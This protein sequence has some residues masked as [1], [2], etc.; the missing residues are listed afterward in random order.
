MRRTRDR[1][2]TLIEALIVSTI[3]GILAVLAVVGYRRWIQSSYLAEAQDMVSNIRSAE[4]SFKAENGGYLPVSLGLGVGSDYPAATPGAF[5]TGWGAACDLKICA[6]ANSWKQLGVQTDAPVIFGYSVM[7][8]N[9][10]KNA[11]PHILVQGVD[12][13]LDK[14]TGAPW[15]VV[16]ADGDVK[17]SGSFTRLFASSGNDQ[18]FINGG[19]Q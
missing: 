8:D 13:A 4:E 3:V 12:T 19:T 5:K 10:G 15:Y 17:G 6:K 11:P 9:G 2:F 1:A 7:A 16:E 18:V 14:L